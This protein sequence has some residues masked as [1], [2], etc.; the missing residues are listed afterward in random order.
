MGRFAQLIDNMKFRW[1][2]K[3]ATIN[4]VALEKV[5]E[6]YK[7]S[8]NQLELEA[9]VS[10]KIRRTDKLEI[11]RLQQQLNRYNIAYGN[12]PEDNIVIAN[13]QVANNVDAAK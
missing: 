4:I 1:D 6:D 2:L 5:I 10:A 13:N 8:I 11:D 3:L 12:L 9:V 7:S